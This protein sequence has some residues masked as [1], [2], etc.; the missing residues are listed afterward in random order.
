MRPWAAACAQVD[1]GRALRVT[2][3][4]PGSIARAAPG[5]GEVVL[6]LRAV[7][8]QE[9]LTWL[10]DGRWVGSSPARSPTLRLVLHSAGDHALTV[11]DAQG[12]W[13]RV[14]FSVR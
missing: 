10:L 6:Q 13:E 5:R 14:A 9:A 11:L 2:G 3:L 1:P 12:R 8:S 7:G 4:E